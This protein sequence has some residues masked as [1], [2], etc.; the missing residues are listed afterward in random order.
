MTG[1]VSLHRRRAARV[2]T[3]AAFAATAISFALP[4]LAASE[5]VTVRATGLELLSGHFERSGRLVHGSYAREAETIVRR[6]RRP[7]WFA[8]FFAL[9]GFA[10]AWLPGVRAVWATL[11]VGGLLLLG[12]GAVW[13]SSSLQFVS[14]DR[15][16]GFWLAVTSALA[17]AALAAARLRSYYAQWRP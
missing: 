4:F 2:A 11:A 16:Y 6:P 15:R 8:F 13:Q 9:V 3:A 14:T 12:L 1:G 7:A 10:V 5:D 17:G